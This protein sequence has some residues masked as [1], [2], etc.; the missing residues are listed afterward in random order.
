MIDDT[1]PLHLKVYVHILVVVNSDASD[2]LTNEAS[3][4]LNLGH[5]FDTLQISHTSTKVGLSSVIQCTSDSDF[6]ADNSTAVLN[7]QEPTA[8]TDGN[9]SITTPCIF[10]TNSDAITINW[11]K[12]FVNKANQAELL[13][14]SNADIQSYSE[15]D[16]T[17]CSTCGTKSAGKMTVG[18]T[19]KAPSSNGD[20]IKLQVE[21]I[22]ADYTDHLYYTFDQSYYLA[23][24]D[25]D[26]NWWTA[27]T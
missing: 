26:P 15:T 17:G 23:A 9:V 16:A 4:V 3:W 11:Y 1:E 2:S 14:A 27:R 6:S 8:N 12:V 10:P 20:E 22:H 24:K 19:Y 18:V 21:I 5:Y 25:Y 13:D 7:P